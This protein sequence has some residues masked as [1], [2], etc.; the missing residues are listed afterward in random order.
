M[1]TIWDR[2]PVELAAH[3]GAQ[4]PLLVRGVFYDQWQ[5]ENQ[6]KDYRSQ[7]EFL[8]EVSSNFGPIPRSIYPEEA[9]RAVFGVLK[10]EIDAGQLEKV[11]Q[12]LPEDVRALWDQAA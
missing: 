10:R 12:S 8:Q 3:L 1:R 4:L 9:A 7:D 11:K 6:P 2:L 5:P